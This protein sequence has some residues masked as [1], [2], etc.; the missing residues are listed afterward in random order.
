MADIV[1]TIRSRA[2]LFMD[3]FRKMGFISYAGGA[4]GGL[5]VHSSPLNVVLQN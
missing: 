5:Q 2:S 1:G 3:R 4:E